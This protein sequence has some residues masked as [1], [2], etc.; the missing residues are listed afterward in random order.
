M[1]TTARPFSHP[2]APLAATR[3]GIAIIATVATLAVAGLTGAATASANVARTTHRQPVTRCGRAVRSHATRRCGA[4]HKAHSRQPVKHA[5]APVSAAPS[6]APAPTA[7]CVGI[8]LS[9]TAL[10]QRAAETAAICLINK[11]R[12][13]SGLPPVVENQQLDAAASAHARDMVARDYFAHTS[14]SGETP[15][16]RVTAAGYVPAGSN[17]MVGENIGYGI[18]QSSSPM[19]MAEGWWFS[20]EHRAN[21]LAPGF[22]D[23][24]IGIVPSVPSSLSGGQPGATYVEDFAG[25][26]DTIG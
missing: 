25:I 22:R 12:A 15:L 21:M 23:I 5:P 14:P 18:G 6:S 2:L 26:M 20:P 16:Q 3:I 24:G 9:P 7:P 10:N 19:V 4:T 17:F 11:L 8:Q 1:P 13:V